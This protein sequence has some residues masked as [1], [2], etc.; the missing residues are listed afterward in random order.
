M[1]VK[2]HYD[3]AT[4]C[5]YAVD[6]ML[7]PEMRATYTHGRGAR[8]FEKKKVTSAHASCALLALTIPPKKYQILCVDRYGITCQTQTQTVS[9]LP[10]MGI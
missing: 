5:T 2:T 3:E 4:V 6:R 1:L 8:D 10:S 9:M 7:S